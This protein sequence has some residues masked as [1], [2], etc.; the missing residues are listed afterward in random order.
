MNKGL[1][2]ANAD[3]MQRT[4]ETSMNPSVLDAAALIIVSSGK[5][6]FPGVP[7]H[8]PDKARARDGL[9]QLHRA[10]EILRDATPGAGSYVNE[11]DY[12]DEDWQHQYWGRHY[13]RLLQI[14]QHYDP[15]GLFYGHHLVGSE[16]WTDQGMTPRA[17]SS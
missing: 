1:A 17:G 15:S 9:A 3:A 16:A 2:H 4:R 12:H 11:S 14:K 13:P 10:Y 8:E 5:Q 6:A 7:G